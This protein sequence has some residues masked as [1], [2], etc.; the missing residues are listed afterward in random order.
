MKNNVNVQKAFTLVELVVVITILAILWTIAFLSLQ[1][2]S[3]D[4]RNSKR[5][6]DLN[7]ISNA[8]NV[9]ITNGTSII[10]Y[11]S[12][13]GSAL[14]G[15]SIAWTWGIVWS[16]YSAWPIN[17]STLWIKQSDFQD[18]KSNKDYILGAT[19]KIGW[20]Y[21]VAT[22]KEAGTTTSAYI[23]WNYVPRT[24]NP[25]ISATSWSWTSSLT[26]WSSDLNKFFLN[27]TIVAWTVTWT[28][29]I[30]S[31][32]LSKITYNDIADGTG[33][34][35]ASPESAWLIGSSTSLSTPV[36]NWSATALPY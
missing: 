5:I 19:V 8:V 17:Y 22:I 29:T 12:N 35:L 28:I 9:W 10:A 31:S 20:K 18:P 25:T 4:A 15:I 33:V 7:S 23:L 24:A 27:D 36:A 16:D 11:V 26:F 14:T 21:E 13:S 6:S 1:W 2:Y 34:K 3:A 30:V 32:D